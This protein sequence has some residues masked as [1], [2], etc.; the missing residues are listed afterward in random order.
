MEEEWN[1]SYRTLGK[2]YKS[3]PSAGIAGTFLYIPYK[4]NY[5]HVQQII[6]TLYKL[7]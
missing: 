6:L 4:M 3:I 7:L 5:L 1:N 2:P